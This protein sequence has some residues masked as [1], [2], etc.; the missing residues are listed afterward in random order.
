[1][2]RVTT[3][4]ALRRPGSHDARQSLRQ[5]FGGRLFVDSNVV[6]DH[7]YGEFSLRY[8]QRHPFIVADGH[9]TRDAVVSDS[10]A[11]FV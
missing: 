6:V 3:N 5:L 1:M 4:E 8:I 7:C 11:Q 2:N 10:V 9:V